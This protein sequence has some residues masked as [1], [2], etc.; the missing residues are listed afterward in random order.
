[1]KI[2]LFVLFALVISCQIP[3][4]C[5]NWQAASDGKPIVRLDKS[6]FA[7]GENVFSGLGSKQSTTAASQKIIGTPVA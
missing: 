6:R 4:S 7:S 2:M 5:Q 1:M 3:A